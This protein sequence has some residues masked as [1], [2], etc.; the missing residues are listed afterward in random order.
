MGAR[1]AAVLPPETLGKSLDTG[2][3]PASYAGLAPATRRPGL[4]ITGEHASHGSSKRRKHAMFPSA[5]ASLRS[6]PVSRAHYQRKQDQA[7]RHNQ[8]VLA[9]AHHRIP[10]LHTTPHQDALHDPQPA[11]K[12]PAAA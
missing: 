6:G 2:A 9:L 3:Q 10:T 5:L 7:K 12:L 4:S 1:T 8:T 11:N